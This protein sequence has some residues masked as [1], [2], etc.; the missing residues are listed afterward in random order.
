MKNLILTVFSFLIL[1]NHVFSQDIIHQDYALDYFRVI[2]AENLHLRASPSLKGDII[3]CLSNGTLVS[4]KKEARLTFN[5]NVMW[6]KVGWGNEN[7]YV[8]HKYLEKEKDIELILPSL[9][10]AKSDHP[11]INVEKPY[12]ALS[13]DTI[14]HSVLRDTIIEMP[15]LG[16]MYRVFKPS[17]NYPL[18]LIAGLDLKNGQF[19]PGRKTYDGFLLPGEAFQFQMN[20]IYA[21]GFIERDSNSFNPFAKIRNYHV[22]IRTM[23]AQGEIFEQELFRMDLMA[24]NPDQ[25]EGGVSIPWLGDLDGDGLVDLIACYSTHFACSDVILFLSSRATGDDL[26]GAASKYTVCGC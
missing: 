12:F 6:I 16:G 1:T 9:W 17:L 5:E 25:F 2:G 20:L 4:S 7:G 22:Q 10:M 15:A 21:D 18:F 26:V 13:Q 3:T 11:S 19:I 23:S 8:A 24:F 14:R